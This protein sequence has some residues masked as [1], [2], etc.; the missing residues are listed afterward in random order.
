MLPLLRDESRLGAIH[1]ASTDGRRFTLSREGDAP[2]SNLDRT[3]PPTG[4]ESSF[5]EGA[6][7]SALP[8]PDVGDGCITVST[9]WRNA[10]GRMHTLTFD[11]SL[12]QLSR[13]TL[14]TP[15]G[16]RGG[17]TVLTAHGDIVGVPRYPRFANLS[18]QRGALLRPAAAA[19]VDFLTQ[20]H[21]R[22]LSAGQQR[23]HLQL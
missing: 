14:E 19:N 23:H 21:S 3:L 20:G 5:A 18:D 7:W 16:E 15:V 10:D 17:G 6:V 1:L 9:R 22:W 4:L 12:A 11:V 8:G 13:L 2:C